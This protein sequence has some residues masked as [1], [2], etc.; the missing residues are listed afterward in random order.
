MRDPR[1]DPKPGDVMQ[2]KKYIGFSRPIDITIE[3][4]IENLVAYSA[5]YEVRWERLDDFCAAYEEAEVHH[6]AD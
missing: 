1:V 4:R 3:A 5:G 6:A 2:L